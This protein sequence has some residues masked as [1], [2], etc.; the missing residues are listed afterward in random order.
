MKSSKI[1]TVLTAFLLGII[2]AMAYQQSQENKKNPL[3][4]AI[5]AAQ[6]TKE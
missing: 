2:A 6:E 4:Q 5:E 3:E 1:I